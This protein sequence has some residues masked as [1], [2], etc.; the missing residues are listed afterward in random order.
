MSLFLVYP[1]E[2][3]FD[4]VFW[5]VLYCFQ[6]FIFRSVPISFENITS[7]L[8]ISSK[9]YEAV[10]GVFWLRGWDFNNTHWRLHYFPLLCRVL[11]VLRW[12]QRLWRIRTLLSERR[13][14][15]DSV[16]RHLFRNF[17]FVKHHCVQ[18]RLHDLEG[19][20]LLWLKLVIAGFFHFICYVSLTSQWRFVKQ[21]PLVGLELRF[22]V[23]YGVVV[24]IVL[25]ASFFELQIGID[26]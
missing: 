16:Y 14:C 5:D 9:S 2:V 7:V 23:H 1:S 22:N 11:F 10:Y 24:P 8:A 3:A 6:R 4:D 15:S 12:A 26:L 19:A 25:R 18:L 20:V 13:G 21:H 17:S